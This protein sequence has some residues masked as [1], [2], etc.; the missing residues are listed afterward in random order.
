MARL[1]NST[2]GRLLWDTLTILSTR[3]PLTRPVFLTVVKSK[4]THGTTRRDRKGFHIE[5]SR[6]TPHVM[7]DTLIHEFAHARAWTRGR[8]HGDKWGRA[9]AEVYRVVMGEK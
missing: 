2:S 4:T 3:L 8:D 7:L 5:I 1:A 9:Y 6:A